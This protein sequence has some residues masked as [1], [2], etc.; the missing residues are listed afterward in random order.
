MEAVP[1]IAMS[2]VGKLLEEVSWEHATSYRQGGRGRENVLSAEVLMALDF[3]P[4]D[5]FLGAAIRAAKG[6][7][8][9]RN[10]LAKEI[11]EAELRFLPGDM[12]L[13][14]NR[15]GTDQLVVQPDALVTSPGSFVLVEAKRVRSSSFQPQQLAKEYVATMAHAATRTPLILLLGAAPPV[16]VRGRGRMTLEDAI[17]AELESVLLRANNEQLALEGLVERIH[18]VFCWITWTELSAVIGNQAADFSTTDPSV[19]ASVQRLAKSL[20]SSI[21]WHA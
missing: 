10:V 8:H 15:S 17:S 9:A 11:E 5:R 14:P 3:L 20:R 6:A 2:M 7:D 13:A 21:A 16:L 19:N 1:G 4:R 18:D 12:A